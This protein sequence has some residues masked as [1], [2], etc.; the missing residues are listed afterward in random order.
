[1]ENEKSCFFVL[2]GLQL[3]QLLLVGG[4]TFVRSKVSQALDGVCYKHILTLSWFVHFV[5]ALT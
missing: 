1:M 5:T 3:Q 2:Q 4:P